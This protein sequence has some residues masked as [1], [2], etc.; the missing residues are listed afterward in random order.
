MTSL[1][2]K[3]GSFSINLIGFEFH[4]I[5]SVS[6]D[7]VVYRLCGCT[8]IGFKDVFEYILFHSSFSPITKLSVNATFVYIS[9]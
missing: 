5:K 1:F 7:L 9:E 6:K 3:W 2:G 8:W 4:K